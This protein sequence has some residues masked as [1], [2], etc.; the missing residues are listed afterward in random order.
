MQ[1][2]KPT[3]DDIAALRQMIDEA[4]KIGDN[5]TAFAAQRLRSCVSIGA[6]L[7]EWKEQMPHGEWNTWFEE[8]FPDFNARSRQRWMHLARLDKEGKLD[9]ESARG[10]RHAYV[11]ANLLP[12]GGSTNGKP[13]TTPGYLVHLARLVRSLDLLIIDKL[14]PTERSTIADRLSPVVTFRCKLLNINASQAG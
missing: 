13:A 7:N 2:T 5:S 4:N 1:P 6:R 10:L 12:E 14:T 8:H 3:A 9:L 11:L